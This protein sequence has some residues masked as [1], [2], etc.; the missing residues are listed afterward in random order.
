[1]QLLKA[2]KRKFGIA[3]PRVAVRTHMPWYLRWLGIVAVGALVYG[4]GLAT[5]DFGMEF[6]G[7][8]RGEADRAQEK[9]RE[10]IE[11]QQRELSE[12]RSKVAQAERQLQ[13]EHATYSDMEKQAKSLS[14]ENA[15][16]KEDLAFFQSLMP[17]AGGRD[18][19]LTINRFR[20]QPE[21]LP[22]EYRYRLL[23][24][25]T[26]LRVNEYR[27]R[28][29]FVLSLQQGDRK[30]VLTLPSQQDK[31]VKEYQLRFKFF[32]RIEGTFRVSPD[33]VVKSMQ[34]RVFENG[35]NAPKLTQTLNVS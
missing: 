19:A 32:Q 31:N 26:G 1:M 29:E 14:G 20:L 9:L 34:V 30:V 4:A 27:G 23:L 15:S 12:L 16:L 35:N 11:S 5:Y 28:L 24:V 10:T 7:F 3:A 13:I 6:A 18:G 33:A 17:A 21:T 2:F 25:Q 22:G 8:R